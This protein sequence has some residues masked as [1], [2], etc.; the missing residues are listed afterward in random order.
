MFKNLFRGTQKDPEQQAQKILDKV[1]K[2]LSS[3]TVKVMENDKEPTTNDIE[4][5]A[6]SDFLPK[7]YPSVVKTLNKQDS[8]VLQIMTQILSEEI[9]G[10][11]YVSGRTGSDTLSKGLRALDV[12][13]R[14]LYSAIRHEILKRG[15]SAEDEF[16]FRKYKIPGVNPISWEEKTDG[17]RYEVYR[18]NTRAKALEFLTNI[19]TTEIPQLFYIIVETP[20]GNVGKDLQGIFDES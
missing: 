7:Y 8:Q 17:R 2:E 18:S 15:S 19:P 13:R 6:T 5:L 9:S 14:L 12:T 16:K 3:F 11:R 4:Y 1:H 20:Q 10:E